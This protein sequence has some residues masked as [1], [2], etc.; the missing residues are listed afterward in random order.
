MG[1]NPEFPLDTNSDWED[2]GAN[3]EVVADAGAVGVYIEAGA[4]ADGTRG[5]VATPEQAITFGQTV[6]DRARE[7]IRLRESG[8][9]PDNQRGR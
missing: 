8:S 5:A 4:I 2:G 1:R 6:L 3:V 7:A 9:T